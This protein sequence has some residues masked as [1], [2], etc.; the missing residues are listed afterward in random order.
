MKMSETSEMAACA[1]SFSQYNTAIY[2]YI[3]CLRFGEDATEAYKALEA[4]YYNMT[5]EEQGHTS[6]PETMITRIG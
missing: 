3:Q 4:A 1:C 2:S 6:T 5:K